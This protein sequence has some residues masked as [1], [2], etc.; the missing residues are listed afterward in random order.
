MSLKMIKWAQIRKIRFWSL[1]Y[2]LS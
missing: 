2:E 1:Y